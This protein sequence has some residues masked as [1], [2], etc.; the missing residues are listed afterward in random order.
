MNKPFFP[1]NAVIT[2]FKNNLFFH[3]S[4]SCGTSY[5][6]DQIHMPVIMREKL[7]YTNGIY[8]KKEH[9]NHDFYKECVKAYF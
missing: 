3:T 2:I 7:V 4:Y 9:T 8:V 1:L 6:T 5:P